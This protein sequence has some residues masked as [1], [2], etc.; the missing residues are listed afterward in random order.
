MFKAIRKNRSAFFWGF[1]T[2]LV[3]PIASAP[4]LANWQFTKWGMSP[5]EVFEASNGAAPIGDIEEITEDRS[6]IKNSGVYMVGSIPLRSRYHYIDNRL[7]MVEL[8]VESSATCYV[9]RQNLGSQYGKPFS[10]MD[11]EIIKE[12]T[13][14]DT[15]KMN[16]IFLREIGE[17]CWLRYSELGKDTRSRL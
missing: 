2:V 3:N 15:E 17:S 13:W 5:A 4:A 12:T 9:F 14:K 10:D 16:R 7:T 1:L 8:F 11:E 6:Q